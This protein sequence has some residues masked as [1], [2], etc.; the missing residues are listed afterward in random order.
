MGRGTRRRA[1]V[2]RRIGVGFFAHKGSGFKN[3]NGLTNS[4]TASPRRNGED[5]KEG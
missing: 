5:G 1:G 2:G 3:P 4:E